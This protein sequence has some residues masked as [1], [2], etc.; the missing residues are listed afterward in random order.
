MLLRTLTAILSVT[1]LTVWTAQWPA[2]AAVQ[3]PRYDHVVIVVL[4]QQE[5]TRTTASCAL[6]RRFVILAF[7]IDRPAGLGSRV[8]SVSTR[9]PHTARTRQ[10]P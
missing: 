8:I 3:L 6:K 4:A 2:R 9:D 7:R 1:V 5:M 10:K